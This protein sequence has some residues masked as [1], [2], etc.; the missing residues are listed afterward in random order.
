MSVVLAVLAFGS[1][2]AGFVGLPAVL[3]DALGV[4]APFHDFL[5]SALPHFE[6][7]PGVT[8]A[9]E[10]TLMATAVLIAV[11]G[12]ALAWW[13]YGRGT[14]SD[15]R[16]AKPSVLHET[17]SHGYWFDAFY[18]GVVVRAADALSAQVLG[19][20]VEAPLARLTL[21]RPARFGAWAHAWFARL[22]G[23]DL[24]AY[25][26]YALIGIAVVLGFGV[27]HG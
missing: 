26:V 6:V 12:I 4:P 17:V 5:A 13:R 3:R 25:V 16:T 7:R 24:Q 21:E 22:Q 15:V 9:T 20:R 27:V 8:H 1:V 18:D 10:A 19:R 23:G 2:V 11:G 14:G